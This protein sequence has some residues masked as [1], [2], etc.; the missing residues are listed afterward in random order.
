MTIFGLGVT[1]HLTTVLSFDDEGVLAAGGISID[2]L[3]STVSLKRL[4]EAKSV[5]RART[6]IQINQSLH[7]PLT[8][9]A[10]P[11]DHNLFL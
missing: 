11:T 6:L 3:D 4:A 7:F 1:L 8:L 5:T 10:R 2:F 9:S